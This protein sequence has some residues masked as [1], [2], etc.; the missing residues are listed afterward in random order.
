MAPRPPLSTLLSQALVAFTIEFDN[1]S[2]HRLPHRT[3]EHGR[4]TSSGPTPW[5]VSM[6]MYFNCMQHVPEQGIRLSEMRRLAR[7]ETNLDG[8]QRWGYIYLAPDP[9]DPRSKP[10]RSEWMVY[11]T[12][13]GRLAQQIWR[14]LLP[15]IEDRWRQRFGP[16]AFGQLRQTLIQIASQL[17][18]GLPDCLPMVGYGLYSVPLKVKSKKGPQHSLDNEVSDCTTLAL[19]ALV[20]RVLLAWALEFERESAVS[21]AISANVL[22]VLD[23]KPTAIRGLPDL[24]GISTEQV[25]I[26]TGWLARHGFAIL[27]QAPPPDR[28]KQIRLNEKGLVAQESARQIQLSIEKRW[29]SRFGQEVITGLRAQLTPMVKDGSAENSPLFAGLQPYPEGW[30]ARIKTP[31]QLPH[32]PVVSHRGGFPDGN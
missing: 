30:R 13:G 31:Q 9:N 3:T 23:E 4:T 11:S 1:E 19:P 25:A 27:Q 8:M 22:R 28:G 24:S 6:N 7:T 10:P 14:P 15:V 16:A 20:A 5:L 21:L 17:D 2:E 12:P 32:Y 26:A 18:R 29:Q